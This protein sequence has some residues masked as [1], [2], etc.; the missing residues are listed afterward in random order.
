MKV[1]SNTYVILCCFGLSLLSGCASFE[2]INQKRF[3]VESSSLDW[4]LFS[5]TI[6]NNDKSTPKIIKLELYGSGYLKYS[7]GKS[8]RVKTGFWQNTESENWQDI[9]T[10]QIV[11]SRDETLKFYQRL[12]DAGVFDK[13]KTSKEEQARASLAIL[14][15]I[16]FEKKLVLTND[17][18]FIKIFDDLLA[19][20]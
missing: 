20:F 6:K 7:S 3:T 19:K 18:V 9:Q 13:V 12:V 11:I 8:S 17:P 14:A 10:D 1:M 4:V 2:A 15:R 16:G 5:R